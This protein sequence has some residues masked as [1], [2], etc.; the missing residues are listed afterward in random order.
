VPSNPL[1]AY[2]VRHGVAGMLAGWLTAGLLL[3]SDVAGVGRLVLT[4]DLFPVPLIMLLTSF[5]LTFASC[6][7][8]AAI[9]GLGRAEP[10]EPAAT[11]RVAPPDRPAAP[12]PTFA[13][14]SPAARGGDQR[15][16]ERLRQAQTNAVLGRMPEPDGGRDPARQSR[17]QCRLS[18]GQPPWS[19]LE[20]GQF[21]AP[22]LLPQKVGAVRSEQVGRCERA[23]Q[24]CSSDFSAGL[25]YQPFDRDAG[26]D[27]EADQRSSRASPSRSSAGVW[28]RP[29]VSARSCAAISLNSAL[30]S[31]LKACFS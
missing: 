8:G 7:M 23:I 17:S 28:R 18:P 30:D 24:Q 11:R 13:R 2:L 29:W 4:S 16:G 21:G 25:V 20:G 22:N 19:R 5:G 1:V 3:G 6:A 27:D 26:V 10:R 15:P 12:A 9:M 14:H 31:P